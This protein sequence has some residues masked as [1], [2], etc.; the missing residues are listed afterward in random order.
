M[1]LLLVLASALHFLELLA[2]FLK[3][4][5]VYSKR[6]ISLTY[7]YLYQVMGWLCYSVCLVHVSMNTGFFLHMYASSLT[8][9]MLLRQLFFAAFLKSVF[10]S[11]KISMTEKFNR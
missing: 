10:S 11:N 7:I 1:V 3:L 6:P 2:E 9:F 4:K 5:L 8:I